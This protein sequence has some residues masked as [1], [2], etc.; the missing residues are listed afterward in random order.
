MPTTRSFSRAL[1]TRSTKHPSS[2]PEGIL[3]QGSESKFWTEAALFMELVA[4]GVIT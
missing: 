3:S 4:F 2:P 1:P